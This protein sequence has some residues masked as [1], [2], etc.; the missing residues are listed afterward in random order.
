MDNRNH[1]TLAVQL[2]PH[3]RDVGAVDLERDRAI[4]VTVHTGQ[5][6]LLYS[7]YAAMGTTTTPAERQKYRALGATIF[8]AAP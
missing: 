6:A 7:D 1:L 4:E 5:Y 2:G 8:L 3:R